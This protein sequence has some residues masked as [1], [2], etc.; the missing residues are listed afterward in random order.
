MC[1]EFFL[2]ALPFF[3][4][5]EEE[6]NTCE[7][8]SKETICN[9]I[10]AY[11]SRKYIF[12]Q[13]KY[14]FHFNLGFDTSLDCKFCGPFISIIILYFLFKICYNYAILYKFEQNLYLTRTERPA[15]FD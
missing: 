7:T 12:A 3:V 5:W 4:M 15:R 9:V 11:V 8:F 14:I 10:V 2:R 1:Q 13:E 6:L